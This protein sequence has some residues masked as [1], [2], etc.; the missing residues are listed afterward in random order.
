[1]LNTLQSHGLFNGPTGVIHDI[2]YKY[3]ELAPEPPKYLWIDFDDQ[4]KG[5]KYFT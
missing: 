4:Y 5:P 1:M 2:V 3:G